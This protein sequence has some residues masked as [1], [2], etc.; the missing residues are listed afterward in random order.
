MTQMVINAM[1]ADA[2]VFSIDTQE[3][4]YNEEVIGELAGDGHPMS[5]RVYVPSHAFASSDEVGYTDEEAVI[6]MEVDLDDIYD[7]EDGTP[8]LVPRDADVDDSD[9]ESE[10]SILET[11]QELKEL[12]D[13]M[14]D[15][16]SDSQVANEKG[17]KPLRRLMRATA[18]QTKRDEQF[19]WGFH[20]QEAKR[21]DELYDWN[22]MN[23]SIGSAV[24][25]FGAVAADACEAESVQLFQDKKALVPVHWDRLTKENREQ[26]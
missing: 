26:L 12:E 7:D 25:S 22:L 4:A 2:G 8:Q 23:L 9:S 18:G 13:F 11:E 6:P 3:L 10:D 1:N 5:E 19:D 24:R 21:Y 17:H 16:S 20:L 15:D 14:G